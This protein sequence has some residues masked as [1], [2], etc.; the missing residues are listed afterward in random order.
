MG[1]CV[2][3][4]GGGIDVQQ[5]VGDPHI[6]QARAAADALAGLS[7]GSRLK[8]EKWSRNVV[9][10]VDRRRAAHDDFRTDAEILAARLRALEIDGEGAQAR[11]TALYHLS[12]ALRLSHRVSD[13]VAAER[14]LAYLRG[15]TR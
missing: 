9:R 15:L 8:I 5:D 7:G 12:E 6:G 3:E 14:D 4:A 11:D 13:L 10:H 2:G 1:K